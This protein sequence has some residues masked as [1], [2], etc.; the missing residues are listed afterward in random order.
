M[1]SIGVLSVQFLFR[2]KESK[3]VSGRQ[4]YNVD[5][6]EF[7]RFAEEYHVDPYPSVFSV[8]L[9]SLHFRRTLQDS[10]S[11]LINLA[12]TSK[13]LQIDDGERRAA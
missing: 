7:E 2:L 10:V 12:L 4:C 6:V 11:P 9:G 3:T 8:V 13:N 5:R 1:S